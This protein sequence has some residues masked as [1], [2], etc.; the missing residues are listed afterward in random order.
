MSPAP[1][2][3]KS[4]SAQEALDRA[5]GWAAIGCKV[6]PCQPDGEPYLPDY[7][8]GDESR[9][10]NPKSPLTRRGFYDATSDVEEIAS[11]WMIDYPGAYVGIWTGGSDLLVLDVDRKNGKDGFAA[12][13]ERGLP[14]GDTWAKRTGNGGEHRFFQT[15]DQDM[16][17][18]ANLSGMEG[19]DVRAG[20]SY[21]IAWHDAPQSRDVFSRDIPAW[22]LTNESREEF[23][24]EG[25]SGSVEDWLSTLNPEPMPSSKVRDF[26][27]NRV[28][29][30][31]E[32][33]HTEM[34]D[35][36]WSLVRMGAEGESGIRGALDTL[37][38]EW[39]RGE[40]DTPVYRRDFDAALRGGI[41]KAGKRQRPV[42]PMVPFMEAISESS[43]RG[44]KGALDAIERTVAVGSGPLE[45]ARARKALFEACAEHGVAPGIALSV[46]TAS[47]SYRHAERISIESVWFNEGEPVY[48]R[49]D[50]SGA[51]ERV[52]A[53]REVPNVA[54]P[55]A[56]EGPISQTE[57]AILEDFQSEREK[58]SFLTEDEREFLETPAGR[59][60]GDDYLDWVKDSLDNFNGPYHRMLRWIVLSVICSKWGVVPVKGPKPMNCAL[61]GMAL[62]PSTSGKSEAWGMAKLVID[63]YYGVENSPIIGDGKK[64]SA[65]ALHH[66]L[67][68]REGLPSLVYADEVQSFLRDLT[69]SHWQGTILGDMSDYYG[70]EVPAKLMLNDKEFSGKRGKTFL[71]AYFTGIAEIALDTISLDQ[72]IDGF[73]FRFLWTFSD[74]IEDADEDD[75]VTQNITGADYSEQAEVWAAEFG[76]VKNLQEIKW[77]EERLVLW[78]ED[79]LE[80]MT[81][82][83]RD[84]RSTL[85]KSSLWANVYKPLNRRFSNSIMK[86][87]TLVAL[88]EASEKV[89]LRHVLIAIDQAWEWHRAAILAVSETQTDP[90]FRQARAL[91]DFMR[92]NA[93]RQVDEPRA[94]VQRSVVMRERRFGASGQIEQLLRQL[95]DEG[96]IVKEGDWFIVHIAQEGSE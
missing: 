10:P 39:L 81:Q 46:V 74:P 65:I 66:K 13:K 60:W 96:W 14:V 15:E 1:L 38:R 94:R 64:T 92:K 37:K 34:V 19:V 12:I 28:P 90:F 33:D 48:S 27:A 2:P 69:K 77:G 17:P 54:N 80:R 75:I 5:L 53:E 25:F 26:M 32:F 61:Y 70:G 47:K 45:M 82:F 8:G 56:G 83:N 79:A 50:P 86:C 41:R 52:E 85:N 57:T 31:R 78:E 76:R 43:K 23:N 42:P 18:A 67:L 55:A 63:S 62:G 40:F 36:A 30:G 49:L 91:L 35:L 84:L 44:A 93:I 72:W 20:G 22:M 59:W 21:V 6:F 24:G 95:S 58:G 11:I 29:A 16:R 73:Y 51:L 7:L 71:T 88:S 89:T 68:V 3:P 87:A 9:R 4:L